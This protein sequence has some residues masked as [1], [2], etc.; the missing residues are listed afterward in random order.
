M[1]RALWIPRRIACNR[2]SRIVFVD[3]DA[4]VR[5]SDAAAASP[6]PRRWHPA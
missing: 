3:S 6:F 5:A 2:S 4:G 1:A